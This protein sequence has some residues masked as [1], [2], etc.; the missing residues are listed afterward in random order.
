MRERM[1]SMKLFPIFAAALAAACASTEAPTRAEIS[2]EI[3]LEATVRAVNAETREIT[4]EDPDGTQ[5][6]ILAGPE[7]RNF[8]QIAVGDTVKARYR[9]SLSAQRL[10]PD[11]AGTE[12]TAGV[13]VGV[14]EAGSKPGVRLGVDAA[15]TV[16][17][18]TVDTRKHIVVLTGPSGELHSVRA[19]REEGRRFVS[20]LKP[21]DRVKLV[22]AEMVALAIEE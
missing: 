10:K 6:V 15:V 14:A 19:Q 3:V 1:S 21:G 13:T 8:A 12:P 9:K 18:E 11:E 2:Q 4:L 20:G 7:V 17:V 22:Y 5:V 16:T